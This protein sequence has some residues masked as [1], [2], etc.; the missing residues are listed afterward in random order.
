MSSCT[1][2]SDAVLLSSS[3]NTAVLDDMSKGIEKLNLEADDN[4]P[5]CGIIGEEDNVNSEKK[6]I[7]CEQKLEHNITGDGD[8]SDD[9]DTCKVLNSGTSCDINDCANCGKEGAN[10]TCNKCKM[11]KYCTAACK[12][13][14]RHK[15]KKQCEAHLKHAAK[16]HEEEAKRATELRDIELFKDPLPYE[17]CPICFLLLPFLDTGRRYQSCC[18]KK[19]CSGCIHAVKIR[20]TRETDITLCPFCRTPTPTTDGEII[21]RLQNRVGVGDAYAIYNRGCAYANRDGTYGLPQDYSK[22]LELYHRAGEL[23]NAAAYNNIAY[24][25]SNGTGVEV[26]KE[27]AIHYYELAAIRGDAVA[28]YNLGI[29]DLKAGNFDRAVKHYMIAAGSGHAPSLD[30]IKEMY[31]KGDATK[32]DYMKAL[33]S[34]QAYLGEVKSKQRDEAAA[35]HEYYR[36][37]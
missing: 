17:D 18:G 5:Q 30:T 3:N 4:T 20:R 31:S 29:I 7:S 19:I 26:D 6:C 16:L 10:N 23:G 11:V 1:D 35:A 32:E 34:Y 27:K 37:Y 25:Y 15:H 33:H 13:K 14:H 12:K 28:R 36:Y 8:A 2:N 22:A 24:A 9:I 21:K